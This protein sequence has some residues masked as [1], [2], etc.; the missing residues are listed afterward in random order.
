MTQQ[1]IAIPLTDEQR[2]I[3]ERNAKAL[4]LTLSAYIR[5]AALEK[6]KRDGY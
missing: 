5:L 2:E 1:R 3:L 6:A 4:G